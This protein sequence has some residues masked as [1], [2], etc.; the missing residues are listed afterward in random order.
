MSPDERRCW[1]VF[2]GQSCSLT[3]HLRGANRRPIVGFVDSVAET[4]VAR[5]TSDHVRSWSVEWDLSL[6]SALLCLGHGR[7][8]ALQGTG[9]HEA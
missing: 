2:R 8:E 3:Y 5:S 1:R 4:L 9:L 6:P 7:L